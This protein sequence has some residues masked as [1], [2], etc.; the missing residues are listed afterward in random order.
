MN[1][2]DHFANAHKTGPARSLLTQSAASTRAEPESISAPSRDENTGNH[3]RLT[4]KSAKRNGAGIG[5][6]A[7]NRCRQRSREVPLPWQR[8]AC[9]NKPHLNDERRA[10][11]TPA[12]GPQRGGCSGGL[13]VPIAPAHPTAKNATTASSAPTTNRI[14]QPKNHPLLKIR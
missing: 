8:R 3:H 14:R 13:A 11:D 12:Q 1:D 9:L 5:C 6:M 2:I 4:N 10:D 7:P